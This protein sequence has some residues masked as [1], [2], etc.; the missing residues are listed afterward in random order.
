VGFDKEPYCNEIHQSFGCGQN[1][2]YVEGCRGCW[3]STPMERRLKRNAI[4]G[5]DGPAQF[6]AEK[7][8]IRSQSN[9]EYI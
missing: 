9:Y 8:S 2:I 7:G 3:I 6:A 1:G 5:A 4:A